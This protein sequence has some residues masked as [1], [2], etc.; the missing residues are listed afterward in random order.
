M[1]FP[2]KILCVPTDFSEASRPALETAC[3]LA[4]HFDAEL[5]LLFVQEITPMAS[6]DMP[7]PPTVLEALSGRG[8]EQLRAWKAQAEKRGAQRVQTTLVIG[9]PFD[10]IVQHANQRHA[11]LIVMGTHGR[12]ALRHVLIG[13]VAEKVVRHSACP[14]L[15]VRPAALPPAR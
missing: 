3:E 14:V 13:S 4:A 8:E 2:W 7:V 10:Q 9:V 1:S 15:T 5:C 12:T 11:D 6:V